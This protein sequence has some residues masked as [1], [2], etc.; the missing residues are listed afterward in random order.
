MTPNFSIATVSAVRAVCKDDDDCPCFM[1]YNCESCCECEPK[2]DAGVECVDS[3]IATSRGAGFGS[4]IFNLRACDRASL[5]LRSS[6][7]V[8]EKRAHQLSDLRMGSVGRGLGWMVGWDGAEASAGLSPCEV[9]EVA[10]NEL[11]T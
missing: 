6:K 8:R 9:C 1:P 5:D 11:A 2:R 4:R 3:S 10:S 7:E